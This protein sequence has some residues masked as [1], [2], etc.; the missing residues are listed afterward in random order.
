MVREFYQLGTS[1][2]ETTT[3]M[4]A[5]PGF[6]SSCAMLLEYLKPGTCPGD[7]G[8]DIYVQRVFEIGDTTDAYV[9]VKSTGFLRYSF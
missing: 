6:S 3:E 2:R 9:Q 5:E 4:P 8:D 1:H 7:Q